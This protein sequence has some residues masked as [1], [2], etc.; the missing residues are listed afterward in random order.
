[1][2]SL[3]ANSKIYLYQQPINISKSFEGLSSLVQ[4]SFPGTLYTVAYFVFLNKSCSSM[5]LLSWD[6][7]G[8]VIFYKRLEKGR[9]I[10]NKK[11]KCELSRCEFLMLFEGIQPIHINK[12]FRC[13]T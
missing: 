3:S 12:R 11:G 4:S 2:L 1:M 7:D 8:S 10:I 9:F 5:K 13:K 6:G